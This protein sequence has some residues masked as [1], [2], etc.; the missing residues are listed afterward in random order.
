MGRGSKLFPF[1]PEFFSQE[2]QK[3]DEKST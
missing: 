3:S 1:E 2:K